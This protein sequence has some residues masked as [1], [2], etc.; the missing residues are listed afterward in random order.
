MNRALLAE[1]DIDTQTEVYIPE[2]YAGS[3][4]PMR[5]ADH[6]AK[7]HSRPSVVRRVWPAMVLALGV[8]NADAAVMRPT[9]P[10]AIQ[11]AAQALVLEQV[12]GF[13]VEQVALTVG[14]ALEV[15]ALVGLLMDEIDGDENDFCGVMTSLD[16]RR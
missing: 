13:I 7:K 10:V 3:V 12:C 14:D 15:D 6:K 4:E 5:K 11:E 9:S 2:T 16:R 1:A 8:S